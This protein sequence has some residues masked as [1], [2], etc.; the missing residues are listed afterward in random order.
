MMSFPLEA[1]MSGRLSE[2]D[3]PN[4]KSF[5][6]KI[7]KLARHHNNLKMLSIKKNSKK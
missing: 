1:A 5:V 3:Y 7:H 6:E 2:K 4:I